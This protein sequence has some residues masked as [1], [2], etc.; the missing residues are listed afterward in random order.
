MFVYV[1]WYIYCFVL[2]F[3]FTSSCIPHAASFSGVSIFDW[4][5]GILYLTFINHIKL[6]GV[7]LAT[8]GNNKQVIY[9][10]RHRLHGKIQ[11]QLPY[12]TIVL[13]S[14]VILNQFIIYSALKLKDTKISKDIYN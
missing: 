7:H 12:D 13:L 10:Y 3:C 2:L 8:D 4:P 1:Q 14:R 5:F 11:I 9:M 6:Y